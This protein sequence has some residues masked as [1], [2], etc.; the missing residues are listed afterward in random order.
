MVLHWKS[1][2]LTPFP[3]TLFLPTWLLGGPMSCLPPPPLPFS[4]VSL[5]LAVFLKVPHSFQC[6]HLGPLLKE[7]SQRRTD[8]WPHFW[9][10]QN[11]SFYLFIY[12]ILLSYLRLLCLWISNSL[13]TRMQSCLCFLSQL[14]IVSSLSLDN[15]VVL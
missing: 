2:L 11:E 7:S 13:G 5:V 9:Q 4:G 12:F 8:V 1:I 14:Y 6:S 3:Y 10:A 15:S